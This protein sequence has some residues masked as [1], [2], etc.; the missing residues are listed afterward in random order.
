V[1]HDP[2]DFPMPD[3]ISFSAQV[4]RYFHKASALMDYPTGLLEQIRICNS[5]YHMRF[6]LRR[7]DGSIEVIQAWRAEH[8]GHRLPVKGGIRYAPTADEDEVVALASLMTYKCALVDVPFGGAKGGIRIDRLDY[9]E[10]ELERITRRYTFELMGKNFIGPGSDVPAPDYGTGPQE[11]AWIA[12][13]YMA[14]ATNQLDA[15]GCVTG[16]PLTQG[17]I[18]GR[19]EA[20]GQGV[21]FG[22]REACSHVD[23]M[24]KLGLDAGLE[25]KRVVIQGLGNVGSHAGRYLQ[26]A[27]AAI[28]GIAEREGAIHDPQGLDV[29]AV[30]EHRSE[31]G[32]ILGFPGATNITDTLDALELDCDILIPAALESQ[33]TG[34][35]VDR[36][37]AKLVAEAANGPVTADAA[38]KL[39]GRGVLILPDLYLNAGGVT[40][41]Y[42]EWIKNLSHVRF[43]RM[44]K[45]FQQSADH[46][47]LSA[48]EGL[49]GKV[50]GNDLY[51]RI[52]KRGG[53]ADLVRSGL[54][55]TMISAYDE[56]RETT[57]RLETD[58]RT[59]AFVNSIDKVARAYMERG[60]FP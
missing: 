32:S 6:P 36:I 2:E 54:E 42:F 9:S 7:D 55:D 41:S 53:E 11:M 39:L 59:G 3:H 40:V 37:Q 31:T 8:S 24:K 60:I 48:V 20:T 29:K 17:G 16:K 38:E 35:N 15:A 14:M 28:T 26:D 56:M 34:E 10:A 1:T 23:D 57:L 52:Q 18:R 27:G 19:L 13:T 30:R 45:R 44:D 47:L 58:L 50:F 21:F 12:D 4:D 49:V 22:V 43:G 46:E 25:G 5:V 33:I 51:D